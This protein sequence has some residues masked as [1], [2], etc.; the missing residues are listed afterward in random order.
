MEQPP[1]ISRALHKT[2]TSGKHGS[3][4]LHTMEHHPRKERKAMKLIFN[5]IAAVIALVAGFLVVRLYK[6]R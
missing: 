3:A 2:E 4:I 5:A 6:D 1:Q